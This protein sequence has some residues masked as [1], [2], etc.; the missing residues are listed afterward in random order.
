M[1]NLD[2][3]NPHETGRMLH[4]A[5]GFHRQQFIFIESLPQAHSRI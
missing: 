3:S 5:A 4:F 1:S 2:K